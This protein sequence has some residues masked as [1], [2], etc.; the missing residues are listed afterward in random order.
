MPVQQQ[1]QMSSFAGRLGSRVA[2]ANAEHK[3]KPI[4]TGNRRLPAGIK[5]GIAKI[6]SAYT[7]TQTED[8]GMVPKGETFFRI[9][10]VVVSPKEHAGQKVEGMITQQMIPMCDVPAKGQRAAKSFSDNW[11]AFQ[12]L[13]KL[14]GVNPPNEL[15]TDE[16]AGK[17]IEAYY[18]AA[19]K[20]LT[21]PT[22]PPTFIEFSTRGWTPPKTPQNPNPEEMVFET[23]HGLASAAPAHDP[24]ASVMASANGQPAQHVSAPEPFEEPPRGVVVMPDGSTRQPEES[25]DL[26][27]EVASLIEVTMSDPNGDT[28][29]GAAA[30]ARLEDLAWKN[31]WTKEQTQGAA[32]WAA[33]GEMAL[34]KPEPTQAPTTAPSS[35][36][37]TTITV[38]Y[39]AK[40]AKRTKDG[41]KLKNSKGVEL[42]PQDVEVV[43]VDTASKTCTVKSVKDDKVITD[44]RTKQPVQVKWEWLE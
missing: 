11:F 33:V 6:Q 15:G 10:A 25:V 18:F 39:K 4:D 13:F 35:S 16:A 28:E 21:D 22:R 41:N 3:D 19:M 12:N 9:S 37:T 29:E 7:K 44:I 8:G 36:T 31:G 20:M 38:G 1:Q 42:P 2:Q 5:T 40:F 14:L 23:W 34:N 24:S 32:D 30:S 26:A 27:D 17:R 43:S